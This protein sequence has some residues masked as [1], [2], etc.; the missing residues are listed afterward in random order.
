MK[1]IQVLKAKIN[2]A[3]I[4]DLKLEYEGSIGIDEEIIEKVNIIP[5]ERVQVLNYN[6]G[7]RIETYVIP[8][9]KG[10]KKIVLYGPA[11]R[12]GEVGDRLC[13]LAYYLVDEQIASEI[14]PCI[15]ELK[16]SNSI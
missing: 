6:N 8:E 14:K 4:T 15:L 16:L 5:G 7:T 13:I 1:L 11:A 3:I 12:C 10:S 2:N 9:K